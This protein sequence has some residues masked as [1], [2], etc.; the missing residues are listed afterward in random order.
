MRLVSLLTISLATFAVACGEKETTDDSSTDDSGIEGDTDTD[1]DTDTDSDS[2]TDTD[3]DTDITEV[4]KVQTGVYTHGNGVDVF[5]DVVTIDGVVAGSEANY[6]FFVVDGKSGPY[7]GVFVY[8]GSS[9]DA[10]VIEG[11]SVTITGTVEE[12]QGSGSSNTITEVAVSDAADI[13]I[14]GSGNDLP[15]P[16]VV[17]TAEITDSTNGEP[18]EACLVQVENVTVSAVGLSGNEYSIDDGAKVDDMLWDSGLIYVGD[19]MT[20]L[21][22][23]LYYSSDSFKLEPRYESDIQ[24]YV[25]VGCGADKCVD[26]LVAG[27]VIVTEVMYDVQTGDDKAED[28]CEWIE[29]YNT[30]NGSVNLYSLTV[31][32]DDSSSTWGSVAGNV[33]VKAQSYAVLN[34]SNEA[35]RAA[36]CP[37]LDLAFTPDG[38]YGKGPNLSNTGDPVQLVTPSGTVVDEIPDSGNADCWSY[39]G[40]LDDK[41]NDN[42]GDWCQAS[43][44]LAKNADGDTDYGTP[45]SDNPECK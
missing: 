45:G 37:E 10:G 33:I 34:K 23:L 15:A 22:G 13:T 1:T 3:T 25:S 36:H 20:S 27:D 40:T 11:D 28:H 35:D 9:I 31:G 19:T 41:G 24:G 5:G 26:D 44:E 12:Y 42:S 4:Y 8:V 18:W 17:T 38:Y 14:N 32:D 16:N 29:V 21:T 2:D 43:D 30:T 7:H 6:G 39:G